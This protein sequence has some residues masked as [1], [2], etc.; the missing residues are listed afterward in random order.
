MLFCVVLLGS[1][2]FPLCNAK[3]CAICLA[4]S[5]CIVPFIKAGANASSFVRSSSSICCCCFNTIASNCD[6]LDV[7]ISTCLIDSFNLLSVTAF[8][9]AFICEARMRT[10]C[11]RIILSYFVC[12]P[13]V[14]MLLS[15]KSTIKRWQDHTCS[16]LT[17][18]DKYTSSCNLLFSTKDEFKLLN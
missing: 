1:S 17:K 11:T 13:N 10:P 7:N 4:I 12:I 16:I 15:K 6:I 8:L 5:S 18:V 3:C 2:I 14:S 9:V